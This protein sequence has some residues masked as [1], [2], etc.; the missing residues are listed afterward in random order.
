MRLL[1]PL[2]YDEDDG[3]GEDRDGEGGA[4]GPV[5]DY[6]WQSA[7]IVCMEAKSAPHEPYN[8]LYLRNQYTRLL[9]PRHLT[10]IYRNDTT[11][12]SEQERYS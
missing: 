6:L 11:Q 5:Q 9:L 8:K 10:C 12:M 1:T 4:G 3:E 2:Y 7:V